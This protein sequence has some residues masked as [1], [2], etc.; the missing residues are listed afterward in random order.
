MRPCE[1][2]VDFGIKLISVDW[3][4]T[5]IPPVFLDGRMTMTHGEMTFHLSQLLWAN[6]CFNPFLNQIYFAPADGCYHCGETPGSYSGELDDAHHTHVRCEAFESAR[7]D[8]V[9]AIGG[10]VSREIVTRMLELPAKLDAIARRFAT[11]MMTAKGVP[12]SWHKGGR[13]VARDRRD[14]IYCKEKVCGA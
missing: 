11:T 5:L 1:C 13:R 12:S 8:V 4:R 2:I 3:T 7:D 9:W 14:K 10:F 6:G